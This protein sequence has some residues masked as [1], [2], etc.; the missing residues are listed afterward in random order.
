MGK[1]RGRLEVILGPMFSGKSTGLLERLADASRR[2]LICVP[3]KPAFDVR[4]HPGRIVSHDGLSSEAMPISEWP[5]LG[6]RAEAVF[7][8]EAQFLEEPHFRGD[9]VAGIADLLGRGVDVTA[10][11]L[12]ADWR[13]NPFRVTARLAAMADTVTM[14]TS[15]CACCGGPA[16][17]TFKKSGRGGAVELGE[18]DLYEPRCREHWSSPSLAR[19]A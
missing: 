11:G 10:C 12:D 8:E 15:R 17:M 19:A 3:L 13:G 6:P 16:T 14:R 18:A 9:A 7:V 1:A 4:Y 5:V 2:G